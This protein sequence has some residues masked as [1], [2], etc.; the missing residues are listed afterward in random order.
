[1]AALRC[2]PPPVP[3]PELVIRDLRPV[4]QAGA[5]DLLTEAFLEFPLL[6]LVVGTDTG[7]RDRLRRIFAMEFEPGSQASA[8]VAELDGRV[9]GALTYL[10]SPSCSAMSAGRMFRFMRIAGPRIVRAIR[11]FG[12]VERVHLRAP[13]RHLPSVAVLPA[14]QSQGIGQRLMEEFHRRADGAGRPAYL[15]TIRWTDPERPSHER[16]YT[17]LDYRVAEVVPIT[18]EWSVLTMIRPTVGL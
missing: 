12:R 9:V 16:F 7:A 8:I 13:H 4:D 18:A 15:E 5:V 1:M 3:S 17:R 14:L 2:Y 10:D 11:V 6:R